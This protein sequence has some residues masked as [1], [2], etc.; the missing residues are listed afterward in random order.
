MVRLIISLI[1]SDLF[2]SRPAIVSGP[3]L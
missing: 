1:L 2:H 3:W